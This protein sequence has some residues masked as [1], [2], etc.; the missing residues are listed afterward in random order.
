LSGNL[1]K[2]LVGVS[3]AKFLGGISIRSNTMG[4]RRRRA[5]L[6]DTD[7]DTLIML[8]HALEE[9]AIDATVTWDEVEASQLIET[10][11]FDLLLLGDHPPE[12]NAQ[13]FS[14]ILACEVPAHLF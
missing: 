14:M 9:A 12:L 11:P 5:L 10:T 7:P 13:R 2:V 1:R 3:G 4:K 8:Q 6:L